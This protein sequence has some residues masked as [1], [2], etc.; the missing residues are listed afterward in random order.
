MWFKFH[1]KHLLGAG[2]FAPQCFSGEAYH[3]DLVD[4]GFYI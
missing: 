4:K 1:G 3:V 2:V